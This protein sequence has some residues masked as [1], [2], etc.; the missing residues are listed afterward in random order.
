[1]G[2]GEAQVTASTIDG[3]QVRRGAVRWLRSYFV[4]LRFDLA[5]QGQMLVALFFSQLLLGVGSALMYGF[6]LGAQLNE[7][8]RLYLVTGVAALALIP[9]GFVLVPIIVMQDRIK[10]THEFTWSLPIPRT[11]TVTSTFTLFSLMALPGAAATIWVA[12]A[13]YDVTLTPHLWLLP[14]ALLTALMG[15]SVGFGMA[16]AMPEPRVTNLITN[17]IIFFVLLFTPIIVPIE[18]F[19]DWLAAVQRALP[20]WHIA[21]LIRAGL[22]EGLVTDVGRSL[23]VVTAWTLLGW[24]LAARALAK[25]G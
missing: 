17:V 20:F 23:L 15:S 18:Q 4:M 13:R 2:A 5:R 6:Y 11:V 14:V 1:M 8:T 16:A 3:L 25:R 7:A 19:P 21:N 22:T 9:I 10:G 24:S 12:A